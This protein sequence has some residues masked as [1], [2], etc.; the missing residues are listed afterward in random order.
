MAARVDRHWARYFG[1]D[2]ARLSDPGVHVTP[3]VGLGDYAGVWLFRRGASCIVSAP[4]E[5]LAELEPLR[6]RSVAELG[7]RETVA[8]LFPEAAAIVGPAFHASVAPDCFVPRRDPLTRML[9]QTDAAAVETL[10]SACTA[11]DWE[12]GGPPN[13]GEGYAAGCF[14]DDALVALATLRARGADACDPCVVTHPAWRA[15]GCGTAA[16]SAAVQHALD[17]DLLTLYLTLVANAP[18][19]AL[20]RALGFDP[21]ATH[22]AV[23]L[24]D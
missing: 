1:L 13:P 9:Q 18:A 22:L 20:A 15:Q 14:R 5:R 7:D 6:D 12:A 16:V 3:H 19:V 4:P 8:L 23:R 11:E 10:R 24:R 17:R 21:Y 2:V